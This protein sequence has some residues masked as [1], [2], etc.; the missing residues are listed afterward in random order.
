MSDAL[1]ERATVGAALGVPEQ[2]GQIRGPLYGL[3]EADMTP[4]DVYIHVA[5]SGT[6]LYAGC[7]KD[8]E[9]RTATHQRVSKWWPYVVDVVVIGTW[10]RDIALAVEKGLIVHYDPPGN[11]VGTPAWR[12]NLRE[13][14][15]GGEQPNARAETKPLAT[16]SGPAGPNPLRAEYERLVAGNPLMPTY[17]SWLHHRKAA[18]ERRPA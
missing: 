15:R 7:T 4:H 2:Y 18:Q 1:R 6:V 8:L 9:K 11:Y 12:A 13:R 17:R 14:H 10:P 5:E 3:G 16:P